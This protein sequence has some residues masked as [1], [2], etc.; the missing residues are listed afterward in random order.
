MHI[1]ERTLLNK[2]KQYTG[3]SPSSYLRKVR[4]E[5]A[6]QYLK[7]RKYQTIKEVAH[8]TGFNNPQYFNILFKEEFGITAAEAKAK[9]KSSH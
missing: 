7:T 1:T 2:L 6:Y 4:L 9:S 3:Q 5:Q 8:A